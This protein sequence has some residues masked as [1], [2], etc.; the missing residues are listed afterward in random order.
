MTA[1]PVRRP[2]CLPAARLHALQ[3]GLSAPSPAAAA[4]PEAT[5]PAPAPPPVSEPF[6]PIRLRDPSHDEERDVRLPRLLELRAWE[7]Q[8]QGLQDDLKEQRHPGSDVYSGITHAQSVVDRLQ[9]EFDRDFMPQHGQ[10]Q[11]IGPRSFFTSM[12]FHVRSK[13]KPR[14]ESVELDLSSDASD[15]A[16]FVGPELRQG[17]GLVFMALLNLCRDYRLGKQACFDA[18]AMAKALWKHYKGQQRERL[19]RSIQRLQ[20]ST[21]ELAHV[22][23]Q[24][25][26][27]FEHPRRGDWCVVLDRDIVELF[28]RE[29]H[30]WLNLPI[31]LQLREGLTTWLYGYICSQQKLI[32]TL[33]ADLR[34]RCGSDAQ[35]KAFREML[36][37]ALKQLASKGII[38]SGW[39]LKGERVHWRKAAMSKPASIQRTESAPPVPEQA[40]LLSYDDASEQLL[41]LSSRRT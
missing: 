11:L 19:K 6:P 10:R 1:R 29:Q 20:R 3:L 21:I 2:E 27:R 37:N 18:A 41:G 31:R 17:D 34:D 40:S 4:P 14:E 24:L 30:V 35:D 15:Y 13:A 28:S 7:Q 22:T 12:L 33:I 38:D 23:V 25:V 36:I 16:R 26:L 9:E 32:P 39:F 8:L 5:G